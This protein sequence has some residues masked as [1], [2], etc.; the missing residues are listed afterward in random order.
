MA[1]G[2]E[3]DDFLLVMMN[4]L[5]DII[6]EFSHHSERP[7]STGPCL[8]LRAACTV[9][10]TQISRKSHL[11]CRDSSCLVAIRSGIRCSLPDDK[12]EA[13]F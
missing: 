11:L 8:R 7:K 3:N 5:A 6:G 2:R 12:Q 13:L 10:A 1:V 4:W 9:I